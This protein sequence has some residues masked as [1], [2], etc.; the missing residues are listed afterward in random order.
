MSLFYTGTPSTAGFISYYHSPLQWFY[1]LQYLDDYTAGF[2]LPEPLVRLILYPATTT[3][4]AGFLS[5][6]DL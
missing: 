6:Q 3:K 1:I 2:N 5:H 4:T